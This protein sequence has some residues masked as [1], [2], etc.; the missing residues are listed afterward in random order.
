M[1]IR[2]SGN[3]QTEGDHD[4]QLP[5][6]KLTRRALLASAGMAGAAFVCGTAFGATANNSA[7]GLSA[8]TV[9]SNTYDPVPDN[10]LPGTSP[11][12]PQV[13]FVQLLREHNETATQLYVKVTGNRSIEVLIPFKGKRCAH[14]AFM[15]DP[16]DDFIKL[17]NGAVSILSSTSTVAGVI[18]YAAKTGNWVTNFPPNDYTTQAGATFSFSF[19]GTGFDFQHYTDNRGGVW[20]FAVDGS[21]AASISTHIDAVPKPELRGNYGCRPVARG[22]SDGTHTVV[23]TFK[24]D[25]PTH[26]PSGGAGTSRG[27]V[28]NAANSA[29]KDEPYR[30]AL[31]YDSTSVQVNNPVKLFEALHSWSNKEFALNVSPA[32]SGFANHWLP[33]HVNVGTVYTGGSQRVYFDDTEV[34]AWTADVTFRPVRSVKIVQQ[35]IAK[36]PNDPANP[37]AEIDCVHTASTSGVSVKVKVRWLRSVF[38]FTGYGMMFPAAGTFANKLVTGSGKTYEA[39]ATDGSKT[40][41]I[42]NDQSASYAYIHSAS[43][44]NGEP[45]TVLAMTIHDIAKTFRYG[46]AGRRK[47]GSVVWLQHRDATMQKL[48]PQIF[49]QYTAAAGETYEAGG[50]YFIGELPLAHRLLT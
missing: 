28:R 13:D 19:N 41:L 27:W 23:A 4:E 7:S 12:A 21:M 15:K 14:Y 6:K 37:V 30:T 40:D 24:G 42:E 31:L 44:T 22:L 8:S 29:S 17:Q 20:E 49:D 2:H 45:D 16:N 36:H 25:D 10:P 34:S 26:P 1:T 5:G 43:G 32:G 39:S 11:P 48:Y 3:E 50:T 47:N 46:Q 35:M 9:S 18:D 33:E 38:I